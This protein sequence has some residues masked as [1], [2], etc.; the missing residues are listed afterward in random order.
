MTN[1]TVLVIT[2]FTALAMPVWMAAQDNPWGEHNAK[3]HHY[4]LIDLGTLGGPA[5]GQTATAM[6]YC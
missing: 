5:C 1:L 6:L 4:K 2:S 3:H